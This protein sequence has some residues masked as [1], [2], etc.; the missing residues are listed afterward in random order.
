MEFICTKPEELDAIASAML[1][2]HSKARIFA[3]FGKLG[4]GKTTFI[5]SLCSKL[6]VLDTAV[7]PSFGI[8][9][10]YITSENTNIYHFDFYRIKSISEF[11][12]LG[13]EEYF[14]SG[15]YCFIEWPEKIYDFLPDNYVT[16]NIEE[17]NGKRFIKF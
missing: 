4:A 6:K 17:I 3:F 2:Y 9:N 14:F 16:V 10:E 7:S 12:D 13:F 1:E 15:S 11:L 8:I 5:K